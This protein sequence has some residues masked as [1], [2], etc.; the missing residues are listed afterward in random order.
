MT[1]ITD[2]AREIFKSFGFDNFMIGQMLAKLEAGGVLADKPLG[3][4]FSWIEEVEEKTPLL[5]PDMGNVH[6]L[7]D[8]LRR[9]GYCCCTTE[10]GCAACGGRRNRT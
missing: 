8:N 2:K 7:L 9:E 1:T 6:E 4:V 3:I 10:F 5:E